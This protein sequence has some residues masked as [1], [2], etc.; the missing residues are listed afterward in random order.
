MSFGELMAG[1]EPR[2][3]G[4]ALT[5]PETWY[6]GRTAY[7][8][9]SSAVALEAARLVGSEGAGSEGLAQLRSA[10]ISFVAPLTGPV[11]A[12][13]RVL[14]RGKNATW[15]SAELTTEAG[16]A[17]TASFAFMK[18]VDS[19]LHLNELPPP[20]D[21]IP[22]DQALPFAMKHSPTF[23][24]EHFEV[25]FALPR[26]EEKRPE[27]C[28]WVRL[29]DRNGLHPMTET[30]LVGDALPPGV[31]PLLNPG[32]PVSSM[33]WLVN[34]LTPSPATRDGWWLMRVVGDFAEQ[35]CSN[36]PMAIWNADGEP[37]VSGMQAVAV[38]G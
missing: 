19:A 17:T 34:L 14:R 24:R 12:R 4:F 25:R 30:M 16:V 27:L 35:G 38:F 21:V 11:E 23:L 36:E 20:P 2:D 8:G 9:F 15:I 37:V 26:G 32:V 10:Q 3:G 18:P 33:T 28:W 22:V 6:Q 29:K 5:V 31:L 13:A 1:A 7:G